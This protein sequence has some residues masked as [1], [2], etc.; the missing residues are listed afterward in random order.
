MSAV[1]PTPPPNAEVVNAPDP[2]SPALPQSRLLKM[3]KENIT[4]H[5]RTAKTGPAS[6]P[7]A[8]APP[9]PPKP[10]PNSEPPKPDATKPTETPEP[11]KAADAE[12]DL[13]E[14]FSNAKAENW[15]RA[16]DLIKTLNTEKKTYAE[17]LKAKDD[18]I[19][20]L[21]TKP[22]VPKDFQEQFEATKKERDEYSAL[23]ERLNIEN[24]PKFKAHFEPRFKAALDAAIEAAGKERGIETILEAPKGPWRKKA[25]AEVLEAIGDDEVA[26]LSLMTAVQRYDDIR[27]ERN[28]HLENSK[29]EA[30]LLRETEAKE[31]EAREK[32]NKEDL[33]RAI[34]T[35][36]ER[37]SKFDA[38]KEIDGNEDH[39]KTVEAN[40][41]AVRKFL[42]GE[43]GRDDYMD[44]P[45][46]AAEAKRLRV[47]LE[48]VEKERDEALAAVKELRGAGPATRGSSSPMNPTGD[49]P[50]AQT[51]Y[52]PSKFVGKALSALEKGR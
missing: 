4:K 43:A 11:V 14:N 51:Y 8:I 24:H 39:N 12:P 52:G 7:A 45:I 26:K 21:R 19:V 5:D 33:N 50:T 28:Q 1:L 2:A 48:R 42:S 25:I 27:S 13:P 16:R 41:E 17:Q 29:S 36:M 31:R 22:E 47:E 40:K 46:Q 23:V 30:K 35:A 9:E 34:A 20:K 32:K 6:V 37:A 44:A 18:E 49:T 3:V 15:K 10:S 38:F